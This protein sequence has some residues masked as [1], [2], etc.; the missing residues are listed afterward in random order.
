MPTDKLHSIANSSHDLS[1]E[2]GDTA[3]EFEG[4][5]C[6]M[7]I[8]PHWNL[9]VPSADRP[10]LEFEGLKRISHRTGI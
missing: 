3:L 10:A 9:K 5:E 8:A 2:I 7:Q 6:I 1:R 4:P